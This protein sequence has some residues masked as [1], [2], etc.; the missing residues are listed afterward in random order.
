MHVKYLANLLAFVYNLYSPD[1]NSC[2]L[3]E[4]YGWKEEMFCVSLFFVWCCFVLSFVFAR[5][6]AKAKCGGI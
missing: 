1:Y 2:E 3:A 5:G 6:L 4:G